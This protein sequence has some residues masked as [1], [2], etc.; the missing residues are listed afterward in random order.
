MR[1]LNESAKF[2]LTRSGL[3]WITAHP[4]LTFA[5]FQFGVEL[6]FGQKVSNGITVHNPADPSPM[7]LL[8]GIAVATASDIICLQARGGALRRRN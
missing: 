5:K 6:S 2:N 4:E 8:S 1:H 7:N 3:R